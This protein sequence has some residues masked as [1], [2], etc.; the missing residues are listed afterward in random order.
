[1]GQKCPICN[2]W[3]KTWNI[4]LSFQKCWKLLWHIFFCIKRIKSH[5]K[6]RNISWKNCVYSRNS[7]FAMGQKCPF[8]VSR[9]NIFSIHCH[10]VVYILQIYG[11]NMDH[12]LTFY[13]SYTNNI[14][15]LLGVARN[16]ISGALTRALVEFAGAS[17]RAVPWTGVFHVL[18]HVTRSKPGAATSRRV[19][20]S[21][22]APSPFVAPRCESTS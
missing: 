13:H 6:F 5:E 1:M 19:A 12:F 3:G 16:L 21:N 11:Q 7:K 2:F 8:R 18:R 4:S 20:H 9:V 10:Y 14:W 15:S 22:A 17:N